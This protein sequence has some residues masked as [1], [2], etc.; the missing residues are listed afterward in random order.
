MTNKPNH[1]QEWEDEG[2][3]I[4]ASTREQYPNR[5]SHEKQKYANGHVDANSKYNEETTAY[6]SSCNSRVPLVV[7]SKERQ[8]NNGTIERIVRDEIWPRLKFTDA[9]TLAFTPDQNSP[10][11]VVLEEIAHLTNSDKAVW[12]VA[13]PVIIKC[14]ARKRT[15]HAS[16]I[17]MAWMSK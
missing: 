10:C 13:K 11:K 3:S 14:I 17:K 4:C 5:D 16:L 2:S 15:E 9:T 1:H 12:N 8:V 7:T 6:Y